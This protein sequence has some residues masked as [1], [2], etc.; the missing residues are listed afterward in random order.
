MKMDKIR[1][2]FYS[3]LMDNSIG[4]DEAEEIASIIEEIAHRAVEELSEFSDPKTVELSEYLARV[5]RSMLEGDLYPIK[6]LAAYMLREDISVSEVGKLMFRILKNLGEYGQV[7]DRIRIALEKM[8]FLFVVILSSEI[9]DLFYQAVQ[10]ATG[11]SDTLFRRLVR[12][13]IGGGN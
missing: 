12:S 1:E 3:M 6:E 9:N 11:M 2:K 7:D 5:A 10:K 13:Q 8:A 4:R